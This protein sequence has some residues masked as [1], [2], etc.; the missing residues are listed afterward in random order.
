MSRSLWFRMVLPL[1]TIA[2]VLLVVNYVWFRD[3]LLLNLATELIGIVVT[4][5]YVEYLFQK[6]KTERWSGAHERIAQR[7][8]VFAGSLVSGLGVR[9]GAGSV[10]QDAIEHGGEATAGSDVCRLATDVLSPAADEGIEA[11]DADGW[12]DLTAWLRATWDEADRL[13]ERF[14]D[15]LEPGQLEAVLDVQS[16]AR[17]AQLRDSAAGEVRRLLGAACRLAAT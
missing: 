2:A 4:V 5:I 3:D 8:G 12:D 7:L 13:L 11:L 17:A 10:D 1:A 6:Y 9:L 14:G 15:R 16:S